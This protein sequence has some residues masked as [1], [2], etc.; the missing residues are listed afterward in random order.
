MRNKPLTQAFRAVDVLS[1]A[2]A[3]IGA[4]GALALVAVT[5][6]A[7]FF[8]YIIGDPIYGI[9]D[10][11]TML[12]SVI[13]AGSIIYGAKIGAHVQVDV[14]NMVG[15]RKVTRY[16]DVVVRLL[17]AAIA[18]LLAIALWEEMQCGEDCGYFTPNLEIVH[19]PFHGLLMVSMAG[20]GLLQILELIE[21]L[22]HFRANEDPNER[23]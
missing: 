5:V 3:A 22:I 4:A 19:A 20:Y 11:S 2:L 21:G 17:S 15:G 18:F 1:T 23:S 14:L 12:L 9:G 7:V 8:R 6:V 13:V 10:L 16:C